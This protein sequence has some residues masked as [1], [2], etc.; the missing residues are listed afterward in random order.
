MSMLVADR[1]QVTMGD[2]AVRDIPALADLLRQV[3]Q[4]DDAAFAQLYDA[5][6][7]RVHGLICRILVDRSIS[8]EVTQEVFLEVWRTSPRFDSQRGSALSWLFTIAHR[9]AVDRVRS[10]EAARHRDTAYVATQGE[11]AY[12]STAEQVDG[13]LRAETVRTAIGSLSPLQ[14][15]AVELAY[16]E[17]IS[18]VEVADRLG[19][20]LGTAKSRIRDGLLK[21]RSTLGGES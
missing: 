16:F 18:H 6:A 10:S 4:G 7:A 8:E 21:L 9:R 3:G 13:T 2:V 19:I 1:P 15:E 20:P 14:R 11:P 5:T 12:D 17:G